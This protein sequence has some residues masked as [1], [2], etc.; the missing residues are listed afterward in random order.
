MMREQ[1]VAPRL[2]LPNSDSSGVITRLTSDPADTD[3]I[4]GEDFVGQF[5]FEKM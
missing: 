2:H 3:F 1:T 5:I 4:G